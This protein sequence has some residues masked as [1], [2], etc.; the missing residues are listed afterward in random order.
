MVE[1][2]VVNLIRA[3]AQRGLAADTLGGP[4]EVARRR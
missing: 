3:R 1:D 2:L 4:V